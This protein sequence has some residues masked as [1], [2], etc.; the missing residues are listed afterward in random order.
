MVAKE[1]IL[2][3]WL[4]LYRFVLH[5]YRFSISRSLVP[6]MLF[7]DYQSLRYWVLRS[8]SPSSLSSVTRV[9]KGEPSVHGVFHRIK[10][11]T[12]GTE[13]GGKDIDIFFPK[14][15]LE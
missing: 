13:A 5:V 9:K 10:R 4:L 6:A 12:P 11:L 8:V 3:P 7:S 1:I 14:S 2:E 15:Q